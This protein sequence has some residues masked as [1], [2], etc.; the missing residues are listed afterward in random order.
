MLWSTSIFVM[1]FAVQDDFSIWIVITFLKFGNF[2]AAILQ[3][4]FL[5]LWIPPLLL[6]QCVTLFFVFVIFYLFFYIPI[7]FFF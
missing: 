3:N 4:I 1:S 2:S 5:F 6:L 7:K